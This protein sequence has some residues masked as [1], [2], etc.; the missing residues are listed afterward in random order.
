[1]NKIE[2]NAL[3]FY[4]H[5]PDEVEELSQAIIPLAEHIKAVDF[6]HERALLKRILNCKTFRRRDVATVTNLL[7]RASNHAR[8]NLD[9]YFP[10]MRKGVVANAEK[11]ED[12]TTHYL[13]IFEAAC[14]AVSP[15][16]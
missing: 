3:L 15:I 7:R 9:D 8:I 5:I 2:V 6:G 13:Q 11:L 16:H 12:A 4:R 1:M 14:H 10:Y